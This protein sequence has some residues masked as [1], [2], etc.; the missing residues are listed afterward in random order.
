MLEVRFS[1][2]KRSALKQLGFG[3]VMT[4]SGDNE[5]GGVIGSGA[6]LIVAA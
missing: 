5:F 6:S 3:W 4:G 2:V 1:E